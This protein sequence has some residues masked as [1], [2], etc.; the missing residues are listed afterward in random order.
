MNIAA[1][2][3]TPSIQFDYEGGLLEIRGKSYPENVHEVYNRLLGIIGSYSEEPQPKTQVIFE[4][5][6]YNT[7]TSKIIAK[8]LMAFNQMD[9]ELKVIWLCKPDFTLMIENGEMYKEFFDFD[10]EIRLIK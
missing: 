1:T 5:L 6:Y 10:F 9:T 3:L 8:I 4:W 2:S 7:A